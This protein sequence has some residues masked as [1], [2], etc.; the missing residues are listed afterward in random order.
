MEGVPDRQSIDPN[1]CCGLVVAEPLATFSR[2]VLGP[3]GLDR[4]LN[5]ELSIRAFKARV[6]C[7]RICHR[8]Q[9]LQHESVASLGVQWVAHSPRCIMP[10]AI[11]QHII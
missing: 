10:Q 9:A 5:H 3:V 4:A 8:T 11:R 6:M 7:K 2:L 1:S